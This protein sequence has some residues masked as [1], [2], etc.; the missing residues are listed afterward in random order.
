MREL[1]DN[2][3]KHFLM[4]K[5]YLDLKAKKEICKKGENLDD[6]NIH[7]YANMSYINYLNR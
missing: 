6:P 2:E 1:R 4:D 5:N 7:R 3:N